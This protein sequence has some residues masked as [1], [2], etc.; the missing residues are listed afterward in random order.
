MNVLKRLYTYVRPYRFWAIIAFGSMMVVAGTNGAMVTLVQPL[1]DDVLR[2]DASPAAQEQ[3][4]QKAK[5]TR[6]LDFILENHKPPEQRTAFGRAAHSVIDPAQKWWESKRDVRWK[7]VLVALA[8]VIVLRAASMFFSE[9]AFERVGLSTVRDLRNAVY[10]S[11]I[12]QSN[13]FFSKRP[14]GELVSR[15]VSDADAVQAAVS[16]R[17]GGLFQGS[18]NLIV[19]FAIVVLR[20]TGRNSSAKLGR[21]NVPAFF[22]SAHA[23]DSGRNGRMMMRGRAGMTPESSVYRHASCSPCT[24]GNDGP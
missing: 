11:I 14:T 16:V 19:L 8:F 22:F 4:A 6:A 21:F 5:R 17:M 13:R 3:T 10:E 2:R 23:G 15:I 12:R 20:N 24:A 1:F 9:Y 7:Y 18:L